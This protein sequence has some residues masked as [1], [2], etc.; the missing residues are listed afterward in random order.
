MLNDL[1]TRLQDLYGTS[2]DAAASDF[3]L[4]DRGI[5]HPTP[6]AV[7]AA[8]V[9][10]L[11]ETP[12]LKARGRPLEVLDAG[13]GDGRLVAALALG[14]P[15]TFDLRLGG[16]ESDALLALTAREKLERVAVARPGASRG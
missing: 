8:A 9:P 12:F 4:T 2:G 15:A 7:L 1:L 14:L 10:L 11:G 6:L 13:A 5:W 3:R 16:L